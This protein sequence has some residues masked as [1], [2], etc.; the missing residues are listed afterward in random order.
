MLEALLKPGRHM[1]PLPHLFGPPPENP[2]VKP[3]ASPTADDVRH[4]PPGFA[5]PLPEGNARVLSTKPK[6][7]D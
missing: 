2:P 3:I 7:K 6:T 4:T 5:D 1:V